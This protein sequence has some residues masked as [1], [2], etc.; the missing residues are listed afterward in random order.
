MSQHIIESVSS[1]ES[2]DLIKEFLK[3]HNSGVLATADSAAVPHAAAIYFAFEDD[4]SLIFITK[5]ETQKYKNLE[6]NDQISFVCYDETTQTTVQMSGHAE[7]I[8]DPSVRANMLNTIY[9]LSE[10]LSKTKLPPIEKLFAGD[11]VVF[12][13]VPQVIKLAIFLRP[14]SEGEDTYE[15]MIFGSEDPNETARIKSLTKIRR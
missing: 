10:S 1:P 11:Y 15:T 5:T 14:D 4:F 13:L 3:S 7:K 9:L 12:R 8:K 6:E 2:P